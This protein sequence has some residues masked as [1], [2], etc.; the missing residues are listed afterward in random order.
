MRQF[1]RAVL[2]MMAMLLLSSS[3]CV[4]F[5]PMKFSP[6]HLSSNMKLGLSS[7]RHSLARAIPLEF[8]RPLLSSARFG[9]CL[10]PIS[11]SRFSQ[12]HN[13]TA[14]KVGSVAAEEKKTAV[15]TATEVKVGDAASEAG[16]S[17]IGGALLTFAEAVKAGIESWKI[18]VSSFQ[19]SS[20]TFVYV[21]N[22]SAMT[23]A[24]A[25][26]ESSKTAAE[27]SKTISEAVMCL[28][29]LCQSLV[30]LFIAQYLVSASPTLPK[31][32]AWM[33]IVISPFVPFIPS[34]IMISRKFLLSIVDM[35]QQFHCCSEFSDSLLTR[36]FSL[37]RHSS[38]LSF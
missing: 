31:F 10:G 13:V 17:K 2:L 30:L 7:V 35:V 22:A 27:S 34:I 21:F 6:N 28:V 4:A 18:F 32:Q 37:R 25:Y 11:D 36:S 26:A 9:M 24:T 33:L 15:L 5:I 29:Q 38:S 23:I 19:E 8:N 12:N 1:C 16:D 20:K 14:I 3:E